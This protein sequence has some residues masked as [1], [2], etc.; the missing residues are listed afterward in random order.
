MHILQF[1]TISQNGIA[2]QTREKLGEV[3]GLVQVDMRQNSLRQN[4]KNLLH[5]QYL[6][7]LQ[8]A[9]QQPNTTGLWLV[10]TLNL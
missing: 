2:P 4:G 5:S 9:E 3:E 7:F 10:K 6:T 1:S 8:F